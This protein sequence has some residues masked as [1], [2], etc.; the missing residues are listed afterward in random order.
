VV[1]TPFFTSRSTRVGL[2]T[3][4]TLAPLVL[5]AAAAAALVGSAAGALESAA[6][7]IAG[8]KRHAIVIRVIAGDRKYSRIFAS[9]S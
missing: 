7:R 3:V 6:D 5:G 4:P 8:I 2:I 9:R 1:R